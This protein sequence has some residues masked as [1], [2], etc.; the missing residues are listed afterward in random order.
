MDA[1][2]VIESVR[3][4]QPTPAGMAWFA[5]GLADGAVTDAQA[6]A[7]AMAALLKGLGEE[8]RVALTLAMRDSGDVL[9]WDLPGPVLDKHST[10]GV[11]DSISLLLAPAL[12]ECG[13]FVPMVSGRGLG[14]T[15]GT[16]DKLESIPGYLTETSEDR[17]RALMR[18]V[19]CAIVSASGRIAPADKRLY[20][21][22]DV[23]GTVESVDLITASILSKKLAAGL[24]ALV[25]DVKVGSGAFLPSVDQAQALAASL[26]KTA[27]G[28]GCKTSALITDMDRPLALTAGNAL[29]VL[30]VMDTLTGKAVSPRLIDLTCALCGEVL[31][32]AGL[33]MDAETGSDRIRET[34]TSGA[35]AARFER[36]VAAQGGPA[37]FATR[38]ADH[39]P[40][41]PVIR[42]VPA[43]HPGTIAR[44][45]TRAVGTAV[46]HLGGGRL[47]GGDPVDPRVGFS[48]LA[49]P[50]AQVGPGAPLAMVHAKD[51]ATADRAIA[52][53]QAAYH[54]GDAPKPQPLV[55]DRIGPQ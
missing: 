38:Y 6:G 27:N 25:L 54:L 11:G 37:D 12:A 19:G 20:A 31:A 36:M 22:R 48:A 40:K 29:E 46:V 55:Q 45:D 4:G 7:F 43:P 35:A 14:H 5:R 3:D 41:A 50:G 16:L 10:G 24:G 18:E 9:A 32:L 1:R 51:D 28:A 26:V 34:L 44:I 47:K 13:A 23:T 52:A 42:E 33:A 53:L 15:G 17:L 39:L 8:A 21:I 2:A 49:E 30:E